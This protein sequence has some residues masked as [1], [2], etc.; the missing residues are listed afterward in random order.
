VN[1]V[2][3]LPVVMMT[4]LVSATV[5]M[6]PAAAQRPSPCVDN[7]STRSDALAVAWQCDMAV[8]IGAS[9]TENVREWALPDGGFR[10][11]IS[12]AP[13]RVLRDGSWIPADLTLERRPDRAAGASQR[14]DHLGRLIRAGRS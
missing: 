4:G 14:P 2:F 11:E 12:A 6:T 7:V 1:L 13:V 3:G 5:P 9:T 8:E 10:R